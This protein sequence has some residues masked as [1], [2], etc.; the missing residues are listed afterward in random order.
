MI[1]QDLSANGQTYEAQALRSRLALAEGRPA[2][3]YAMFETL[4]AQRFDHCVAEGA[5]LAALQLG[6]AA[7]AERRLLQSIEGRQV[8][9]KTWNRLGVAYDK[10]K[11]WAQS[12]AAYRKSLIENPKIPEVLNNL[13]Y[14]LILQNRAVE[15][16][17]V[18]KEAAI[19]QG[20]TQAITLINLDIASAM[21]GSFDD[22]KR[23]GETDEEFAERL[24]N[25]G[26]GALL[27]SSKNAAVSYLSRALEMRPVFFSIAAE[28]LRIAEQL[29]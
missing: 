12:E 6:M 23:E 10:Q 11:K 16:V 28:N 26:Y 7:E 8:G 15:A 5:G 27:V 4:L 17:E 18:L 1:A 9:W 13:G 24:N 22:T 20:K 19:L 21:A 29:R 14:S 2:E 3:A 25:A